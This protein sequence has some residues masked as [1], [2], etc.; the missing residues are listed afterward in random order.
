MKELL[1]RLHGGNGDWNSLNTLVFLFTS[2][3]TV[4]YGNHPSLV[5]TAPPCQ[6]PS[7]AVLKDDEFSVLLPPDLRPADNEY[8]SAGVDLIGA[9]EETAGDEPPAWSPPPN[10]PCYLNPTANLHNRRCWVLA[11]EE[12]I[13]DFGELAYYQTYKT[14]KPGNYSK[15]DRYEELG[16]MELPGLRMTL[17][18]MAAETGDKY[19]VLNLT[20]GA[21]P[22]SDEW[23]RD[24]FTSYM[25]RCD[26]QLEVW[27]REEGK[28]DV[29]KIYTVFFILIGI[30]LLGNAAGALGEEVM[31]WVRKVFSNVEMVI[32]TVSNPRPILTSSS[33]HPHLILSQ[34]AMDQ[35]DNVVGESK[36]AFVAL[37]GL[38]VILLFGTLVFK[39]LEQIRFLDSLYFTVVTAT[40]V[41]FGDYV[42]TSDAAKYFTLVYVPI[43]VT[44]VA[45]AI[46]SSPA[47]SAV[48][49]DV[50]VNS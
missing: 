4:G 22:M 37:S 47:Q 27:R 23:K 6:Y 41:G 30:G 7:K 36:G 1:D 45:G 3:T 44:M 48:A 9:T 2:F 28:K 26:R 49:C 29:A 50:W 42:P 14:P 17:N 21:A 24:C 10:D 34:V 33:P 16:A 31:Q 20:A 32:D 46:V 15:T 12:S 5:R 18:R 8:L 11:D 13:F 39:Q 40:T 25:T 38:A 19:C 35:M 43:S